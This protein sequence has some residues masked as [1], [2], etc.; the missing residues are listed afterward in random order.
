V[1]DY[2]NNSLSTS[3]GLAHALVSAYHLVRGKTVLFG[4]PDTIMSP[5]NA[6][7]IGLNALN[8]GCDMILCLF[9]TQ[10]PDKFGMVSI[11]VDGQVLQIVDKPQATKLIYMW[12]CIIWRPN[13]TEYLYSKV[14]KED[15]GDFADIINQAISDGFKVNSV[16]FADG[17]FV[18]FGTFEQITH[19]F[20]NT[21]STT[22]C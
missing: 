3:P 15:N 4:M 20:K 10:H 18:D 5:T 13:F 12:G 6:F 19:Y 21:E 8:T 11:K 22:P 14:R 2:H 17:K 16:K 1:Q 9:P 7:Q